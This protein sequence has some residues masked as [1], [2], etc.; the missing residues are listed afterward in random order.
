MCLR[1]SMIVLLRWLC[2]SVSAG[3]GV[4]VG[5][6]MSEESKEKDVL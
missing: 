1:G 3:G 6:G 5:I 2:L 4:R